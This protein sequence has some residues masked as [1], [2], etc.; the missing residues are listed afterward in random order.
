MFSNFLRPIP[1]M[2]PPLSVAEIEVNGWTMVFRAVA[3][4]GDSVYDAWIKGRE[5]EKRVLYNCLNYGTSHTPKI[6]KLVSV[7]PFNVISTFE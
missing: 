2:S 3:G 4:N 6:V 1:Y 5:T 7:I